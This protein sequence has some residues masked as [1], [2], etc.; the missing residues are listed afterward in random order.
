MNYKIK[1]ENYYFLHK[2]SHKILNQQS[3]LKSVQRKCIILAIIKSLLINENRFYFLMPPPKKNPKKTEHL[4][5][6][7]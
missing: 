1:S 3:N 4:P 6:R 7:H 2:H 5:S